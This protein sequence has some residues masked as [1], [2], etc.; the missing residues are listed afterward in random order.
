MPVVS[1]TSPISNLAIIG[2]LGL[3]RAR[4]EKIIIPPAV[5][6]ELRALR[7]PEGK[8]SIEDAISDGWLII[9]PLPDEALALAVPGEIDP[10][11]TCAIQLAQHIGAEKV[12]LDD[13]LARAVAQK[14]GLT[15]AGLLA[16][17]LFAKNEGTIESVAEEIRHLRSEAKFFI[18]SAI[19]SVIL[20]AAGE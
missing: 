18:S 9:Q 5:W 16:E 11:E 1:N 2:R 15:I 20:L 6:E 4:Y 12:L 19:E 13:S 17:L 10:G 8:K 7:H 3:L 14:L